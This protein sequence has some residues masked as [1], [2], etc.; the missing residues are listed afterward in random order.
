MI[1]TNQLPKP[2]I[3]MGISIKK[4]ITKACAVMITLNNW[5]LP[6]KNRDPPEASSARIKIDR[7]VPIT[8]ENVPKSKYK[9]PIS[10]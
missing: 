1:G 5:E 8:P 6:N 9:V 3:S 7:P 4:I 2:E 10:L